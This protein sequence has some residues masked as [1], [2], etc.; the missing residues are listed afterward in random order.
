MPEAELDAALGPARL[1]LVD[2]TTIIA[3]HSPPERAHHLAGHVFRRIA[4]DDDPL[5]GIYSVATAAECLVRPIRSG[6]DEADLM[7]T[8]LAEFP[9]LR[10]VGIDFATALQAAVIRAATNLALADSLIVASGLAAGCDAV[11]GNDEAWTRRLAALFP[12]VRWVQLD[13][14]V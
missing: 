10:P 14:F 7:R 9:N 12:R 6:S 3:F 13:A 2:S 8:F 5:A 11:V 1:A 4:D